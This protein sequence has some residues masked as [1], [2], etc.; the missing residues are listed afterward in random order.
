VSYQ[1]SQFKEQ[2]ERAKREARTLSQSGETLG[3]SLK[4]IDAAGKGLV[5]VVEDFERQQHKAEDSVRDAN[6]RTQRVSDA[7]LRL[8][9]S[10]KSDPPDPEKVQDC[11]RRLK[12]L[13]GSN[14]AEVPGDGAD[15]RLGVEALVVL[16]TNENW[17]MLE[18][19]RESKPGGTTRV[20]QKI[21]WR[22]THE[23]HPRDLARLVMK[24]LS[25]L[26]IDSP[27]FS[28]S[29]ATVEH[30]WVSDSELKQLRG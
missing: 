16:A 7:A 8:V 13:I 23:R 3:A 26:D 17:G 10:T 27:D 30:K 24:L 11:I 2:L 21:L 1:S 19:V 14:G 18:V 4:A 9:E 22:G 5:E 29:W 12:I 6:V 28:H 20:E 25:G 15:I